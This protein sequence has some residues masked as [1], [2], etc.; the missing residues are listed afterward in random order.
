[1]SVLDG[2]PLAG[3]RH[4]VLGHA[5]K[6]IGVLRALA[7][8]A[9]EVDCDSAAEGWWDSAT[10]TFTVR[11][12]RYP[13]ADS[14]AKFFAEKYRPT[15]IIAA[16][17]KSG[18]VTDKIEVTISGDKELI[19]RLRTSNESQLAECGLKKSKK[20]STKG[21]L[22]FATD[23]VNR[24]AV[25]ST[26]TTFNSALESESNGTEPAAESRLSLSIATK[27]S[28][29]KDGTLPAVAKLLNGDPAFSDCMGLAR[30]WVDTLRADDATRTT[31]LG[32]RDRLP[33]GV[34]ETLDSLSAFHLTSQNNNPLFVNRGQ[35]GNTDIF[36]MYWESFL[37]YRKH[38]EAFARAAL[39]G[40]R[41]VSDA[42]P[43]PHRTK[44]N[45]RTKQSQ[46]AT[47]GKGTPYF[48]DAIKNYNQG[49]E[50]VVETYPFCP[51]DYM[52]A[53]EGALAMRGAVSKSLGS[54]AR[55]Y[56][57]FPF[58]FEGTETMTDD[59]GEITGLGSSVWLPIWSRPTTFD[60]L[61]SFVLDGQARLP[62]KD[63]RFASDF[64]RAVRAQGVDAGF[65]AFQEFRFKMKGRRIPWAVSGRYLDCLA[66]AT[67]S[68]INELLAPVDDSRFLDQFPFRPPQE[69]KRFGKPDLHPFRAPVLDAIEAAVSEPDGSKIL[70]V[71]CRLADLNAQLAK[72]KSLR[73]KID[74][75]ERVIFVSPLW[76]EDWSEA[77][78]DLEGDREFEIARALASIQGKERQ[79]DGTYSQAEPFLGS[80]LP[81]RRGKRSWFLPDPASPQAVWSGIDLTR[82]LSAI[83]ARRIIDSEAD[84]R[85]ALIGAC[86]TRLSSVL[87][88][89]RGELDDAR[90]ARL[91][92]GLSLVDWQQSSE[93][94]LGDAA[95]EMDDEQL[96][97]V[98]VA[99]A[100]VRSLVEIAS[101]ASSS[102]REITNASGPRV[103]VQ[104]TIAL[105]S[106][107]EPGMV[108]A[109]V[110]EALR[111]LAIAG[112]PNTYGEVARQQ[113]PTL[114][115]RDV[116][117]F[118]A[119]G[120][121]I[122][123]D[124]ALSR[125]LAAAVLIPLARQDRWK[126]FRAIT[127]PQTT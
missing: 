37:A 8:C 10:A 97:A 79:P 93:S 105:V 25:E 112:V 123:C 73:R 4:D 70:D 15:P 57:A 91:V 19:A 66:S 6:A 63:C 117:A 18:G 5:L 115:G 50:W 87:A 107:A 113:K 3:C 61:H 119:D 60:E 32:Y 64:A 65:S 86:S 55:S 2:V 39:F 53:V 88:F 98:P 75:K 72:S 127:L 114:A 109:G 124:V 51:L 46:P 89:L 121:R 17:N 69:A 68:V 38:P 7:T 36:R 118:G 125:R 28:G 43:A 16:W 85:P 29:K 12:D 45:A 71:L 122:K 42:T 20:L 59:E 103:T 41:L 49:L 31:M 90:I 34:A 9:S 76:C 99:Y 13:D 106:R 26:I 108:V 58:V 44:S 82:D 94:Q 33:E 116:I 35:Q 62:K 74:E 92:E 54:H 110:T 1:M 81:L 120:A 101:Q 96:D 56:A 47:R 126:L 30:V 14:L 27:T 78:A 24:V 67:A 23:A 84:F 83:L 100:A 102:Q 40:E 48:P 77:L 111:R 52:L 11:S 104:R 95:Q 22:K 21:D 80:L